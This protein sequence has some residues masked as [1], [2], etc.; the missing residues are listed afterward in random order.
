MTDIHIHFG[1]PDGPNGS[2]YWS[3]TFE[4]SIAFLA[5]RIVT[6]SL[7]KKADFKEVKSHMFKV[8]RK[9]KHTKKAVL[10]A[11]DQVYDEAGNPDRGKTNLFTSNEC[12]LKLKK[13]FSE[14]YGE[15]KILLG[16]S[17]NPDR[18]DWREELEKYKNEAALCKWLPSAQNI[19]PADQKYLPFYEKL[20]KYNIPLLSH[21]GP[22]HAISSWSKDWN[23]LNDPNRLKLPLLVGVKVIAAHCALPYFSDDSVDDFE[24]LVEMLG[25]ADVNGWKLYA[26]ISALCVPFRNPYIKRII[27]E[28]NPRN[29]IYGSDY[30]IPIIEFTYK[31][32]KNIFR[33]IWIFLKAFFTKNPL[34]KNFYLLRKMGFDSSVFSNWQKIIE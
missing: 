29:L 9:S 17:I 32:S 30:P 10:L 2:C 13:E 31:K 18:S 14:R 27:K 11:L 5:M 3:K 34:D 16:M 24:K 1:A 33:Q 20:V 23:K 6:G 12:L 28:V 22:E 4:K 19:N 26:D 15:D 25:D 8:I 7:F 21:D